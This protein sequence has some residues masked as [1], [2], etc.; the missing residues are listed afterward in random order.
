MEA[1]S[2]P[3]PQRRT[4]SAQLRVVDPDNLAHAGRVRDG[5]VLAF[6]SKGF[7]S[8][9]I[10]LRTESRISHVGFAIRVRGILC[11]LEARERQGVRIFPLRRYAE[12]PSYEV[13]WYRLRAEEFNLQRASVIE[14]ALEQWGKLYASPWQFVRSFGRIAE[15]LADYL[16]VP[17][18]VNPDRFFCSE[19]VLQCLR[20]ASYLGNPQ[21]LPEQ[22]APGDIVELDCLERMCRIA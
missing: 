15:P 2:Q 13:D 18:S 11:A 7:W 16:G 10:R 1:A 12:D 14:A 6:K 4:S 21:Y 19:F 22:A 20:R 3:E 8:A 9:A 5:D 17:K